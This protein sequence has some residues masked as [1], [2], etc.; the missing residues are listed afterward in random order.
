MHNQPWETQKSHVLP[1]AQTREHLVLA[2]TPCQNVYANIAR[3]EGAS[4][5]KFAIF[6]AGN[7]ENPPKISLNP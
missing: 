3:A 5:G 2:R 4:E 6:Q 1:I 7:E